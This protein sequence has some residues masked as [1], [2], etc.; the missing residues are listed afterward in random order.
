[1][2]YNLQWEVGNDVSV[3]L[4]NLFPKVST[5]S[6]LMKILW[7]WIYRFFQL[8]RDLKLVARS[9]GFVTLKIGASHAS[10]VFLGLVQVEILC[11]DLSRN[12]KRP[13][14][15]QIFWIHV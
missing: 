1:M 9:K 10:L 12:F 8:Q 11:F 7:N 5:K 6:S 3:C 2:I 13:P 15:W 14:D 4:L